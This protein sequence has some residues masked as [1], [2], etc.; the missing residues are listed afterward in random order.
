MKLNLQKIKMEM[1]RQGLTQAALAK[2]MGTSNQNVQA[3]LSGR[4]GRT[5][6]VAEMVA[7]ALGFADPKDL[8]LS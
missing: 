7:T 2:R 3:I 5:F 1:E 8:I 4:S 6:R